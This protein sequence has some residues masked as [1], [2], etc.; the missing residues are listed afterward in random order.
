MRALTVLQPW[1]SLIIIGAKPYEFRVW[2]LRVVAGE[3]WAVHAGAKVPSRAELARIVT[4]L[5]RGETDGMDPDIALPLLEQAL[6]GV[7]VLPLGAVL[8]TVLGG[9][10]VPASSLFDGVDPEVWANPVSAPIPLPQPVP[11]K[12]KQGWWRWEAAP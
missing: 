8:G 6:D 9:Q 11:A 4:A 12:G 5:Y 2:P 1:A 10:P 7:A 3:R